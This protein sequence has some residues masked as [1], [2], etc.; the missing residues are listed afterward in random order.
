MSIYRAPLGQWRGLDRADRVGFDAQSRVPHQAQRAAILCTPAVQVHSSR[1][2]EAH[3]LAL[4]QVLK[5]LADI[6]TTTE[7]EALEKAS[8]HPLS[9]H[10]IAPFFLVM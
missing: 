4:V 8:L 6:F 5:A 2:D 10:H 1:A 9:K 7:I 3:D